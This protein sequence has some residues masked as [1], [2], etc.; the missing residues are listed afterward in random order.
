MTQLSRYHIL[1]DGAIIET[2]QEEFR[3]PQ[4]DILKMFKIT[5]KEYWNI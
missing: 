2:Y 3:W 1:E 5:E 4:K